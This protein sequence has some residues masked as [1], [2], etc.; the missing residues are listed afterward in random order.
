VQLCPVVTLDTKFF[1]QFTLGRLQRRLTLHVAGSRRE[2]PI[3]LVEGRPV[4][5]KNSN[6]ILVV[7]GQNDNGAGMD[8]DIAVE[9][10]AIAF[11]KTPFHSK[12]DRFEQRLDPCNVKGH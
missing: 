1:S 2:F 3:H 8:H 9:G 10:L 12:D 7:D 11:D 4:L 6:A 5:P